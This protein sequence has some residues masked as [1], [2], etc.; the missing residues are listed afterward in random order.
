MQ[1]LCFYHISVDLHAIYAYGAS[2]M[3]TFGHSEW[4]ELFDHANL[5]LLEYANDLKVSIL[6]MQ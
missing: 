1:L 5:K 4:L 2:V 3:A 6:I